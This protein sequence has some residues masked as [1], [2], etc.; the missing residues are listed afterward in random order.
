V[1]LDWDEL[2]VVAGGEDDAGGA[3]NHWFGV[4]RELDGSKSGTD[5]S[6]GTD[7]AVCQG[8]LLPE[9]G[10]PSILPHDSRW[11][12]NGNVVSVSLGE[13]DQPSIGVHNTGGAYE[14]GD[15]SLLPELGVPS[16]LPH[17][18]RGSDN[19]NV[20][21]L[22][23][24]ELYQPSVGVHDAGGAYEWGDRSLL[25]ELGV[26]SILPH[27]SRGSDNGN[28]VSLSLGELYQPSVGVHNAGG[29]YDGQTERRSGRPDY[30]EG[31]GCGVEL[32]LSVVELAV[33]AG[34]GY[35]S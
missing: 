21:S 19:G 4:R 11:S 33:G 2:Y 23:L 12:N 5:L 10:V 26:H 15:R 31:S 30:R 3:V 16:I 28:V 17:D 18:S 1:E 8:S 24:G 27:D 9:L 14:G 22:R 29:A 25:S 35:Y 13:L 7:E 32:G 20:V 6:R 34:L